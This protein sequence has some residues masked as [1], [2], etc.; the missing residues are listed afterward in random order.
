MTKL[1]FLDLVPVTG[2][3]VEELRD[4]IRRHGEETGSDVAAGLLAERLFRRAP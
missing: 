4:L 2:E 3:R 1:S